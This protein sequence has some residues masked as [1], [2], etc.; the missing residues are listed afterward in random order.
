LNPGLLISALVAGIAI[1]SINGALPMADAK[2]EKPDDFL[3]KSLLDK[4]KSKDVAERLDARYRIYK[5]YSK[6]VNGLIEIATME[7][8]YEV[9][10]DAR[11]LAIDLLAELKIVQSIPALLKTIEF[12]PAV[13]EPL[14]I[15]SDD[16]MDKFRHSF[17][18]DPPAMPCCWA[19]ERL[20]IPSLIN[21]IITY[22]KETPET[23]ISDRAIEL[24]ALLLVNNLEEAKNAVSKAINPDKPQ[25]NLQRL[26]NKLKSYK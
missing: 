22:L 21:R 16:P 6:I 3:M 11:T 14:H 15:S 4:L 8:K 9:Q 26:F 1:G 10:N 17:S 19:L 23:A 25:P 20:N 12:G 2:E 24:I 18:L 13:C 5:E 7:G